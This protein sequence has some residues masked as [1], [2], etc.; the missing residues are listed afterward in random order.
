MHKNRLAD[1]PIYVVLLL[2]QILVISYMWIGFLGSD[3]VA[4]YYAGA[5]GWLDHPPFVGGHGT[6]RYLLTLPVAASISTFGDTQ[7]A[8]LLP[9]LIYGLAVSFIVMLWSLRHYSRSA[10]FF[11]T[12]ALMTIP[13]A[14]QYMSV[15]NIDL[16][17]AFFVFAGL[18]LFLES[19]DRGATVGRVLASG[20]CLGAAFLC[21]ETSAFVLLAFSILF[22]CGFG[23]SRKWYFVLGAGFIAI[24]L[25][26][27][28]YLGVMTGD[29][30]YRY[31]IIEG[32][33]PYLDRA[34]NLEG[35]VR[36]HPLIDPLLV[37]L[38][39]QEYA[40]LF[41]LACPAIY[42]LLR[43]AKVQGVQR[44]A[45]ILFAVVAFCWIVGV[46]ALPK[47]LVLNTRYFV[48][49]AML[50]AL[51]VGWFIAWQWGSKKRLWA[52]LIGVLLFGG[53]FAAMA[54]DNKDFM[55]GELQ[56]VK[57]ARMHPDETIYTDEQS[58][59]RSYMLLKWA[60]VLA[61]VKP[62]R[63]EPG[64]IFLENS[65]RASEFPPEMITTC[66]RDRKNWQKLAEFEPARRFPFNVIA[67]IGADRL[68]PVTVR[69]RLMERHSGVILYRVTSAPEPSCDLGR[70]YVKTAA[71]FVRAPVRNV[72]H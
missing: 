12:A 53:N 22:L 2:L 23:L 33:D 3:D 70:R 61:R 41:W 48:M 47:A 62:S 58:Y 49:P 20:V 34:V 65:A 27:S 7:L 1:M 43:H 64:K 11:G 39:N 69:T 54:V 55:F 18:I 28:L 52:G 6:I 45:V 38:I 19:I 46:A 4:W 63:P 29:P 68:L 5:R 51:P 44:N 50:L 72:M 60:Q 56:L 36:I 16:V 15:A 10:A 37:I 8:L 25:V 14:A 13:I 26:Q 31:H 21:R 9:S 24:N 32:A 42:G 35:N 40:L 57:A 67:V 59:T 66:Y 71:G 17:E 30:L